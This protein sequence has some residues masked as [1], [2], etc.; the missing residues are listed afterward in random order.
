MLNREWTMSR[1]RESMFRT[2]IDFTLP[3]STRLGTV[4]ILMEFGIIVCELLE[5]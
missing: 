4:A 5:R 1:R 3:H 2:W